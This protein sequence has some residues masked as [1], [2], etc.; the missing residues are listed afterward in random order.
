M[1]LFM[2]DLKI[3]SLVRNSGLFVR[4][5]LVWAEPL[6]RLLDDTVPIR[7]LASSVVEVL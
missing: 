3:S 5:R 2:T 6:Y 4:H 7:D 1:T